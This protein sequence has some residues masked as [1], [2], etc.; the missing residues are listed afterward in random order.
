MNN[1]YGIIF[2]F[3]FWFL[4]FNL[5]D[6][7]SD[8]NATQIAFAKHFDSE[9]QLY[10]SIYIINLVEQSGKEEIIFDAYG[11]HVVKY[12]NDKLIYVTFDFHEYWYVK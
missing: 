2:F 10:K 6:S 11:N 1:F 4:F 5:M 3:F 9:L 8:E 7:F 12:N